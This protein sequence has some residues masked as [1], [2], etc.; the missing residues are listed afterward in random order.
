MEIT[1]VSLSTLMYQC[2][3]RV[4]WRIQ[5]IL[6]HCH[7]TVLNMKV[8]AFLGWLLLSSR[9]QFGCWVCCSAEYRQ[10]LHRLLSEPV[11][12]VQRMWFFVYW[13]QLCWINLELLL[14]ISFQFVWR[15]VCLTDWDRFLWCSDLVWLVWRGT[16]KLL[17]LLHNEINEDRK[18]RKQNS[19]LLLK[20]LKAQRLPLICRFYGSFCTKLVIPRAVSRL[21]RPPS[22]FAWS[23][24]NR[25]P[26]SLSFFQSLLEILGKL[27]ALLSNV[28]SMTSGSPKHSSRRSQILCRIAIAGL[29]AL[30]LGVSPALL[31]LHLTTWPR[32]TFPLSFWGCGLWW[33]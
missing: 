28:L 33:H 24:I 26:N 14:F 1:V 23:F 5:Q 31:G 11:A 22:N 27:S 2:L 25:S 6:F 19:L 21:V 17:S 15:N 8:H 13:T 32:C 20:C 12:F 18:W 9:Q 30:P 10:R 7:R 4:Q 16:V 29:H 3:C